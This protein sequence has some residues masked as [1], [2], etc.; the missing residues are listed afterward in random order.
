MTNTRGPWKAI[1]VSSGNHSVWKVLNESHGDTMAL[2]EDIEDG[3]TRQNACLIAAAPE[4]LEM[5]EKLLRTLPPA[6]NLSLEGEMLKGR[7][8]KILTKAKGEK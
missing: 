5:V 2:I 7:A 8:I 6:S 4:L 3:F 1:Q